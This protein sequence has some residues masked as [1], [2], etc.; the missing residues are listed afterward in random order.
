MIEFLIKQNLQ[1]F[2][3]TKMAMSGSF[4]SHIYEK[5]GKGYHP[6]SDKWFLNR[7]KED[8]TYLITPHEGGKYPTNIVTKETINNE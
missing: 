7:K 8:D 3:P 5:R 1:P 4:F 6:E 2:K